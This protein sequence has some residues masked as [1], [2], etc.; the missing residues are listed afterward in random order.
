MHVRRKVAHHLIAAATIAG[1][2]FV[3]AAAARE[4]PAIECNCGVEY[5]ENGNS[6]KVEDIGAL[7]THWSVSTD[8]KSHIFSALWLQNE[9]DLAAYRSGAYV[10]SAND[11]VDVAPL[12]PIPADGAWL[13]LRGNGAV[14][15]PAYYGHHRYGSSSAQVGRDL[16]F[17]LADGGEDVRMLVQAQDGTTL[18]DEQ[19][20]SAM[21]RKAEARMIPL[22]REVEE[23]RQ[24]PEHRCGEVIIMVN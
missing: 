16:F 8:Q 24:D 20:S 23:R 13:T 1:L 18:Y 2:A 21:I 11:T 22:V 10:A 17:R 14:F 7:F 15:G 9:A 4:K 6:W 12:K 5:G 3:P 19:I